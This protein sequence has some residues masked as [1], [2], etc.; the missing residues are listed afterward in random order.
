MK[1]KILF[2]VLLSA[3]LGFFTSE[4]FS[5]TKSQLQSNKKKLENE[6]E[7]ANKLLRETKKNQQITLTQVL[8]I[9]N[10]ITIREKL[11]TTINVEIYDL[12]KKIRENG[13]II[14]A[15]K[16]DLE[17]L[18]AE[19]AKMIYHAWKTRG[20]DDLLMF[21]LA[22]D[23][24]NQAYARLKYMQQYSDYRKKQV[25]MIIKTRETLDAKVAE[26]ELIKG[27]K[28][29]LLVSNEV[30]KQQLAKDKE[31]QTGNIE[32]LKKEE[33]T[34]HAN[35]RE[36]QA[37]AKKLQSA[38]EELI[39]KELAAAN[40][41]TPSGIYSMTP[42]EKKLSA[43]FLENKGKLP[44]PTITGM[45]TEHFGEHPHAILKN[46]KIMN[47][48]VDIGTTKGSSARTVFAGKVTGVISIPGAGKAVI[49]R[50]GNYLTVYSN[51][52]ET[53]VKKG[54]V[55]E[56][57]QSIG[58]VLTNQDE[59]KTVLHL[60]IWEEQNKLNPEFWLLPK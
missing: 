35:I 24:F 39:R 30:E 57:K 18:K 26:L 27:G 41:S 15:L 20:K 3:F 38:I 8:I 13:L 11:I 42:E 52:D 53:Y 40:K 25:A 50:H 6:I 17:K 54:D 32:K 22:A 16:D 21:I 59:G 9:K 31:E 60:E 45:I 10:K 56:T 44:W 58:M 2:A 5:Q 46:V 43:N 55:V 36:K 49:I 4:T 34:I 48:G 37:Q 7:Y 28:K 12:D 29:K 51:L 47:N 14:Q 33:K 23:N 1:R 19:Y